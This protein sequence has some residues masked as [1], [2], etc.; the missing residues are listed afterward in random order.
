MY[1]MPMKVDPKNRL[2]PGRS[3]NILEDDEFTLEEKIIESVMPTQKDNS[4]Y[5]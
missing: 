4:D 3:L 2:G 5:A 1:Y